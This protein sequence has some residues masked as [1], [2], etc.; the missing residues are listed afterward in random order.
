M[1]RKMVGGGGREN[2]SF[3]L[4]CYEMLGSLSLYLRV[5]TAVIPE[6]GTEELKEKHYH[7]TI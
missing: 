3:V 6:A 5:W 2:I 7:L 4:L 1:M